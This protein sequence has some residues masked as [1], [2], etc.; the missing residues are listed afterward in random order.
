MSKSKFQ[1]IVMLSLV[2]LVLTVG[3]VKTETSKPYIDPT[4][5]IL[6]ANTL[7]PALKRILEITNVEHTGT[8]DS[9]VQATQQAWLRKP[10]VERW[11]MD[12]KFQ[13]LHDQLE[14]LFRKLHM[15]DEVKP[16]KKTYEDAIILGA[17]VSIMRE[18]L[19]YA[20][21]LWQRG[22]RFN[23]L[24]FLVGQ[25]PLDPEKE[26]AEVLYNRGNKFLPIRADW[27]EPNVMP[28][29][30]TEMARM[31]YDQAVLPA[32]FKEAVKVHFIDTPMQLAADGGT[33][34][35]NTGDTI[36]LWLK[37]MPQVGSVLAVSNQPY[38]GYQHAVLKTAV[39]QNLDIETVGPKAANEL[40]VDVLLD[41]LARWLYQENVLHKQK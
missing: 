28:T 11:Q 40:N 31:V 17:T 15:L 30:E 13:D 2:V 37:E 26:S 7:S 9:V 22:I 14:P 25:R 8:L 29:T 34:R 27:Q 35:P 10:G 19:A 12:K 18:R 3:C 33:R 5:Y 38:V 1:K 21:E 4:E 20:L 23:S 41:N 6:P 16:T 32:G 39:P 24:I 36:K